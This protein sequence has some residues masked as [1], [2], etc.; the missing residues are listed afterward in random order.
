MELLTS[1]KSDA[2]RA[3]LMKADEQFKIEFR[4]V[5]IPDEINRLCEFD[6]VAFH[7]HPADVFPAEEWKNYESYWMI[8]DGEI[9]GCT[10]L[11][12]Y[13][14]ELW[15]AST[16]V[17][18]GLQGKH[19]GERLKQWQIDYAK[20]HAF[21]R[22]GTIMRQSNAR[23]IH[24]NEKFGFTRR[25][26]EPHAYSNPDEAG[27]VMELQLP[28]SSCPKCGKALRTPRAKQCRF[29]GADWH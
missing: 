18:T 9:G 16:A 15:I 6:R 27:L 1:S 7:A 24:L 2:R 5:V 11:R 22:L 23:I 29:C 12:H 25:R 20:S 13:P 10:A 14:D 3:T 19:L 17:A 28:P 21:T 8:V 26:I 4:K